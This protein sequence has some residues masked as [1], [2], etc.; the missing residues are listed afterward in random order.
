MDLEIIYYGDENK[1][2]ISTKVN[3][4]KPNELVSSVP[5]CSARNCDDLRRTNRGL[6]GSN[7]C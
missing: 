6:L 7:I 4:S 2:K 1:V 3:K 5:Y